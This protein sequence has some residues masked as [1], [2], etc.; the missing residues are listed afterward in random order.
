M[1]IYF[2]II[3]LFTGILKS[4]AA[5]VKEVY[6]DTEVNVTISSK[7]LTRIKIV[8][9]KILK[10]HYTDDDLIL[11]GV[12]EKGEVYLRP[13][14]PDKKPL[15]AFIVTQKGHTY[16]VLFIPSDIPSGQVILKNNEIIGEKNN[17]LS[18]GVEVEEKQ[19]IIN[20]IKFMKTGQTSD[21]EQYTII[22]EAGT[23]FKADKIEVKKFQRYKGR[24]FTG[25]SLKLINKD[26]KEIKLA[27]KT[28]FKEGV[29]AILMESNV[30]APM[31]E[32]LLYIIY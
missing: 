31:S 2:I 9:D 7:D 3:I 12:D 8:D 10:V 14:T 13:A 11:S 18:V 25:L 22:R 1:R 30:I 4:R 17:N 19:E 32:V 5:Q 20:L 26:T 6:D 27:E 21:K 16:Q 15:N 23:Y 28:F 24:Q 29:R